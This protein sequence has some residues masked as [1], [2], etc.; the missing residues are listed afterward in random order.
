MKLR[1]VM[2]FAASTLLA[3]SAFAANYYVSLSGDDANDGTSWASAMRSP[4]LLAEKYTTGSV[5]INIDEGVYHLTKPIVLAYENGGSGVVSAS[6]DPSDVVL[7]GGGMTNCIV[8]KGY[9]NTFRGLTFRNA[10]C[11]GS[12]N[13]GGAGVDARREYMSVRDCVFSNCWCVAADKDLRGGAFYVGGGSSVSNVLVV[14]C[15]VLNTGTTKEADG[16]GCYLYGATVTA[17]DLTVTNCAAIGPSAYGGGV[18]NWCASLTNCRIVGNVAT[19]LSPAG[20]KCYGGGI[21]CRAFDGNWIARQLKLSNVLVGGNVSSGNGAG[22]YCDTKGT[23]YIDGCSIVGNRS[24]NGANGAGLYTGVPTYVSRTLIADNASTNV[25]ANG[26][27]GGVYLA[28]GPHRFS[29][30]VF[31]G[32]VVAKEGGA[33]ATA[34]GAS[35]LTFSNCVISCN[36]ANSSYGGF[37]FYNVN[38]ALMTDCFVISNSAP[39][40]SI[41]VVNGYTANRAPFVFRNSYFYGNTGETAKYYGCFRFQSSANSPTRIDYCTF[42][43]NGIGSSVSYTLCPYT[44]NPGGIAT[45]N[46]NLRTFFL[47]GSVLYGNKGNLPKSMTI[48]PDHVTYTYADSLQAEFQDPAL[49]NLWKAVAPPAF[50]DV[51]AQDFSHGAGSPLIDVGETPAPAWMGTGRKSGPQDMGDGRYTIGKVGDYGVTIVRSN[52]HR[53]LSNGIPDLGCFEYFL[54]PGLLMLFR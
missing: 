31:C 14:D 48:F 37:M 32:N 30:C 22:V 29:D 7:D 13:G 16:G 5:M 33:I 21:Y 45:T 50:R 24:L 52:A 40:T 28:G 34:E 20:T 26:K 11:G 41:G 51:A 12:A 47:N 18:Y 9:S 27:G 25:A 10:R 35:D 23:N 19:N 42:V 54:P 36:A 2:G 49:H 44:D 39:S 43:S 8:A 53:R 3:F 38:S 46:D 17:V 6:G 15:G 1:K 4:E